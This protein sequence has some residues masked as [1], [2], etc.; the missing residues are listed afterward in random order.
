MSTRQRTGFTFVE[1]LITALILSFMFAGIYAVLNIGN[2]NFPEEMGLLD[3]EQQVRLGGE[4][5][6]K[7]L[8]EVINSSSLTVTNPGACNGEISFST[9]NKS[10]LKYYRDLSD[11]NGDGRVNQIIREYPAG[12]RSVKAND[13][14]CLEFQLLQNNLLQIKIDANK[15][16][17]QKP[18]SFSLTE[19]AKIR[20]ID[21]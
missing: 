4:W 15:T 1:V 12:T 13:I 18:F 5:L 6:Q 21:E 17:M 20:A 19:K 2:K 11:A 8:R 3:L 7:D 16:V 9:P 14:S 10:Q